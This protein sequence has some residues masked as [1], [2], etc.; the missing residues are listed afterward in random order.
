MQCIE[1]PG[2]VLKIVLN[3]SRKTV[4]TR[5]MFNYVDDTIIMTMI[6]KRFYNT[7]PFKILLHVTL[8]ELVL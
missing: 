2:P 5:Q 8:L 1:K 3:Q 7:L 4:S 6:L